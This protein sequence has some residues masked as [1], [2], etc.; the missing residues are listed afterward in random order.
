MYP[1]FSVVGGVLIDAVGT[2]I[3]PFPSVAHVYTAVARE[4]GCEV[5]TDD[6]RARFCRHFRANEL[7]EARGPLATSEA[8]EERRWRR[9]VS[10]VLPDLPDLE[11]G[12]RDLWDHF[13]RPESWRC[14]DDAGPALNGLESRGIPVRIASNFDSRLRKVIAGMPLLAKLTDTLVISSEVGYRKPHSAFYQAACAS[15]GLAPG[16]VLSVGDDLENDVHGACR[17]GLQSLLVDRTRGAS[18]NSFWIP[19]LQSLVALMFC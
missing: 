9:M 19:D 15:L 11:G 6:V 2:L 3:E 12:F 4:Q 14:F 1:N 10:N 16:R 17:A 13:A 8:C 7:D 18:H 5:H